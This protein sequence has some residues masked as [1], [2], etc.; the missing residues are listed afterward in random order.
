VKGLPERYAEPWR[1]AFELR[2]ASAAVAGAHVLDLGGGRR[3]AI[4]HERRPQGCRYAGLDVSAEELSAAPPGSYD[5][6]WVRDAAAPVPELAGRF[7]LVVSWQAL[8]HVRPLDLA[9]ENVRGYLK[10]GGRLLAMLSGRFAAFALVARLLPDRAGKELMARLIDRPPDTVFHSHYDRCWYGALDRM[11]ASW[12][13]AE[14]IPL[15]RGAGYFDFSPLLRGIYVRYE[16]WAAR[17]MHRNLA[18]HYLVDA[19]R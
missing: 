5:E 7:D 11:L 1:E 10:P 13:R 9:L 19:M 16:D 2:A 8:E 3:P 6:V 17:G 12:S 4:P 18:T 14:I 15:Y